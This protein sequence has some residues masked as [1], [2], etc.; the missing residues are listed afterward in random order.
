MVT[1]A[2]I[3]SQV[4]AA[5]KRIELA[6]FAA[7][8]ARVLE[9][10]NANCSSRF[11]HC[12]G[13]VRAVCRAAAVPLSVGCRGVGEALSQSRQEVKEREREREREREILRGQH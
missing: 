7:I 8:R 9:I 12:S 2:E 6:G 3:L 11:R 5:K 4:P 13:S 10:S 1:L